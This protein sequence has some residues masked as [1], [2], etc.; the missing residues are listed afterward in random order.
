MSA[1]TKRSGG[2]KMRDWRGEDLPGTWHATRKIDGVCVIVPSL[3]GSAVSRA[4]KPLYNVPPNLEPGIYECFLGGWDVSVSALRTQSDRPYIRRD[5][6][7][8]LATLQG[9]ANPDPRLIV[10]VWSNPTANDIRAGLALRLAAGDEGLVLRRTMAPPGVKRVYI[11][12]KPR[13]TYDVPVIGIIPGKGKHAGRMGALIT[14]RG[15][16][17]TGFSDVDRAE[18]A[19][20]GYFNL[21]YADLATFIEVECTGLTPSGKFRHPRFVRVRWDK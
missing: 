10:G 13:V 7:Y 6:F 8:R 14:P 11:K 5:A 19:R 21:T 12:V 3:H 18:F 9:V 2:L 16:V 17:G 15:N 4:G 1:R 20:P